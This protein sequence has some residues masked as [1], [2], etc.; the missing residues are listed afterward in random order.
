MPI[1]DLPRTD[2]RERRRDRRDER[3]AM[4]RDPRRLTSEQLY[5]GP[6]ANYGATLTPDGSVDA[7][8]GYVPAAAM[9][10]QAGQRAATAALGQLSTWAN[11][12]GL[13]GADRA[14]MSAAD[15]T[16]QLGAQAGIQALAQQAAMRGMGMGGAMF[17]SQAAA[18]QSASNQAAMTAADVAQGAMGRQR[19]AVAGLANLG[20]GLDTQAMQRGSAIDEFNRFA[21]GATDAATLGEYELHLADAERRRQQRDQRIGR[22]MAGMQQIANFGL[23]VGQLRAASGGSG[24]GGGGGGG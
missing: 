12:P 9:G 7:A 17:A 6:G 23:G 10:S 21:T 15:F 14:T 2:E 16:A 24:G 8:G 18:N 5:S 19:E 13:T 1:F 22:V 11:S 20:L 3:R 4:M